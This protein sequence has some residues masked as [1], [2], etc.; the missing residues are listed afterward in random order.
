MNTAQVNSLGGVC[1]LLGLVT[2]AW[3]LLDVASYRG[4]LARLRAWLDARRRTVIITVRRLLRRPPHAVTLGIAN[5]TH[6]V[7]SATGS[8]QVIPRPFRQRPGQSLEDQIAEL[9]SLVNRL[10]DDLVAQDREH[11]QAV[12]TLRQQTGDKLQAEQARADAA[13][14]VVREEMAELRETTTGGLRLQIDG[15]LSVLVG[16]VFTTWSQNLAARLPSWP[17]FPVAIVALSLYACSRAVL[18]W[19]KHYD[20]EV[21]ASQRSAGQNWLRESLKRARSS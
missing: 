12:D 5:A 20:A 7:T 18:A 11:R 15:L 16:V 9:G 1:E 3:G 10:R 8:M 17:P 6:G 2:V 19:V 14:D 13:L 21:A 4:D